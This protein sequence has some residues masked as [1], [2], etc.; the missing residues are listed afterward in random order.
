MEDK[1]TNSQEQNSGIGLSGKEARSYSFLKVIRALSEPGNLRAQKEAAFEFEVS[2]AAAKLRG[3]ETENLVIPN[4]VLARTLTVGYPGYSAGEAAALVSSSISTES[5]Y[6]VLR[7]RSPIM[8]HA[9]LLTGLTNNV[10]IPGQSFGASGYWT[11]EGNNAPENTPGFEQLNMSP[12]TIAAHSELSRKLVNQSSIDVENFLRRDMAKGIAN[13]IDIALLRG[14]DNEASVA[15]ITATQGIKTKY[16]TSDFASYEN[17]VEM[18]SLVSDGNADTENMRYICGSKSRRH[19]KTTEKFPGSG[20]QTIWEP[21]K[22]LNGYDALMTNHME[23]GD[24]ILGDLENMIVGL[25]G[26]LELV[27]DPYS[28]S[29]SGNL[30][31]TAFQD[32]DMVLRH[33]ESFA[34]ARKDF[35]TGV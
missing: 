31:V 19:F 10:A 24:I 30:I 23:N 32:F 13:T 6:D 22:T 8:S 25:W 2:L 7:K 14:P 28:G 15:G 9:S 1:I 5:F 21:G 17:I 34:F 33:P 3:K 11:Y 35:V 16:F 18:E 26:G 4:E 20:G 27:V 12:K 29:R